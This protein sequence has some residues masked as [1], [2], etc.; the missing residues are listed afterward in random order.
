MCA[1]NT[2][3]TEKKAKRRNNQECKKEI[4]CHFTK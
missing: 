3:N 1:Q 2:Q 4:I